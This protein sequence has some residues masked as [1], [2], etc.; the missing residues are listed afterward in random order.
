M[1]LVDGI[2]SLR[3]GRCPRQ[4]LWPHE[5]PKITSLGAGPE[6]RNRSVTSLSASPGGIKRDAWQP[7][8]ELFPI[9]AGRH[10]PAAVFA[11]ENE[12]LEVELAVDC[13]LQLNSKAARPCSSQR[14]LTDY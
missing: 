12:Y 4:L 10:R 3:L 9:A 6:F 1:W 14:W 8:R 13:P 5:I 11:C 7:I 2:I